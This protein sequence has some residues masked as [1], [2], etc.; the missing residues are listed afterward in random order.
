MKDVLSKLEYA[1]MQIAD[2]KAAIDAYQ[3]Q[4]PIR[5]IPA[6]YAHPVILSGLPNLY[7]PPMN[8]YSHDD[9]STSNIVFPLH[10]SRPDA[11]P[12]VECIE[13]A[14][15]MV[16]QHRVASVLKTQREAIDFIAVRLAR[17]SGSVEDNRAQF[18]I[19]ESKSKY[20][21]ARNRQS[22]F[23]SEDRLV[24][25]DQLRP[26]L[27]GDDRFWALHERSNLDK[28]RDMLK[29]QVVR[30]LTIHI[31]DTSGLIMYPPNSVVKNFGEPLYYIEKKS[32]VPE[33]LFYAGGWNAQFS[34]ADG[35]EGSSEEIISLLCRQ[36][37]FAT[38][39]LS[40]FRYA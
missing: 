35:L 22:Q 37:E 16:I 18:P 32:G 26:Y 6:P 13:I 10:P 27:G 38:D 11:R 8:Q 3:A 34:F 5:L 15:P 23:I 1:A 21:G 39:I 12:Y 14:P 33:E 24:L 36:Q 25:I 31:G 20:L 7:Q 4:K 28:H 30:G 29:M 2:A 9:R 19:A 17:L 40:H